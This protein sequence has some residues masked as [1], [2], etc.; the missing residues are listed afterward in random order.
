MALERTV[1]SDDLSLHSCEHSNH[2]KLWHAI[3]LL[4]FS[5][6]ST[7]HPFFQL[8]CYYNIN[9]WFLYLETLIRQANSIHVAYLIFHSTNLLHEAFHMFHMKG[10]ALFEGFAI[11]DILPIYI[12]DYIRDSW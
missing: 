12:Y 3:I 9:S 7:R 1:H 8:T 4:P 10:G 11:T 5:H 2:I 6:P